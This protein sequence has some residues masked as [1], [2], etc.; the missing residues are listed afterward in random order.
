V[1]LPP[2]SSLNYS[3]ASIKG[4]YVYQIRGFDARG[5]PYRQVGVFTADGNGNITA[6]RDDSS[7]SANGVAVAGTYSVA[8]DG[9]GFLNFTTSSV[10]QISLA[11]TVL[12][13]SR[14]YLME[15]DA[16][17][18]ATGTAEI[19]DSAA[20]STAP[21]GTFVFRLH[22]ELSAQGNGPAAEVGAVGLSNGSGTG[23]MDEN[24]GGGFSSANLTW[25]AGAPGAMGRGTGSFVNSS[26][27]F[28]TSFVYYV[29]S[30][31]KFALLVGNVAAVGSGSAE[32]QSGAVGNG[33]SGNYAF[34][35]RG[36]DATF[37]AGV[38]T[39]GHFTAQASL[40]SG[41]EDIN[42]DGKV[43]SSVGISSCYTAAASG[44]VAVTSAP[45]NTC[46]TTLIQVFWMVSPGRAFFVDTGG[47][48]QEDG[49]ADLQS[50]QNFSRSTFTQPFGI[51]M[52]G[53]DLLPEL[54]SRI[55]T[56]T[57]NGAGKLTL[58]E[59]VNTSSTGPV[60][61]G[62]MSGSYSVDASGRTVVNLNNGALD[63]VMYAVSPSQAYVL[64][65]D[66]GFVTSGT[67]QL[68]Q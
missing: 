22:Q 45:G 65:T 19:Q 12:S 29:V 52:A 38:A 60:S 43:S 49:T 67:L 35:S 7:L 50:V 31:T 21:S 5:N 55:G 47:S 20:I 58:N 13:T 1:V 14:I 61:P 15:A 24:I 66:S 51:A 3:R 57:F 25:T 63:L 36:D 2:S 46:S 68:Q 48:S 11:I 16:F 18:N 6:G 54:L 59:L 56:L 34:G 30:S 39:V 10:G 23:S 33:L 32:L 9:T 53:L 4:A 40:I 64:Q 42:Q 37:Y 44:R 28:K 17:A 26:T 41:T 62:L 8:K 27:S